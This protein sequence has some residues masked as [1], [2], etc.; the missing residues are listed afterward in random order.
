MIDKNGN[1]DKDGN[2]VYVGD[3]VMYCDDTADGKWEDES[4]LGLVVESSNRDFKVF[5]LSDGQPLT[6]GVFESWYWQDVLK[7]ERKS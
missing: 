1:L 4:A 2:L 7:V 6:N 3:L 5:L